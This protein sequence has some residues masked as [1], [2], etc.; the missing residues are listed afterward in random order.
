MA[1]TKT[2]FFCQ[3]CGTQH[4]QWA[5]Q[6]HN[7]KQWNTIVE[8]VIQKEEKRSWKSPS[9]QERNVSIPLRVADIQ[10]NPEERILS[11][12]KELDKHKSDI[13]VC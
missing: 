4:A 7:C 12:N 8:E 10:L 9:K 6:C 5:G 2:T 3:N 1:K 13:N 11:K